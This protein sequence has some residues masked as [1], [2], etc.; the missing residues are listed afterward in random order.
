MSLMAPHTTS[1]TPG[2]S[3]N[4]KEQTHQYAAA[5]IYT[6]TLTVTDETVAPALATATVTSTARIM[7][8]AFQTSVTPPVPQTIGRDDKAFADSMSE[9]SANGCRVCHDNNV[10]AHHAKYYTLAP[11]DPAPIATL[12][13]G[14]ALSGGYYVC[15]SCH[16]EDDTDPEAPEM[17]VSRECYTC[18]TGVAETYDNSPHHVNLS[19]ADDC[20]RCHSVLGTQA[21]PT[22][23]PS[24][25][26]PRRSNGV[27][28]FSNSMG[29]IDTTRSPA[30]AEPATTV[31]T[32]TN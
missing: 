10:N 11:V 32:R 5:G 22:Y 12:P 4:N 17:V 24:N 6:V 21:S 1:A 13:P 29:L 23:D 9:L 25:V 18:H 2:G 7:D 3:E 30:A 16:T 31:T 15:L 14:G 20:V 28:K 8:A 26:T 19:S 27:S